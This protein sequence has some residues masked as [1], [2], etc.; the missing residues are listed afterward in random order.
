MTMEPSTVQALLLAAALGL[1]VGLQREWATREVAGIRSFALITILGA[2]TG[3]LLPQVGGW[4]VAAGLLSVAAILVVGDLVQARAG[5]TPDPGVTTE[6]AA[7]VMF[8]VGALVGSG[9]FVEGTVVGGVAALLLQWKRPLHA[10]VHALG[11]GDLRAIF[12][13]V[14]LAMVILPV[15]PNR[16]FG[17]YGVLNPF[18]IWL[19]VVLIVGISIGAYVAQR[20][21]GQ[22]GGALV[23]GFLG[24]L[25][26]ST[27][28]TVSY[29]R[30]A[31]SRPELVPAA[32]VVLLLASAVV[33][34]R[35][36]GE[37]A[38]VAP[39]EFPVMA[40][41]LVAMLAWLVVIT[42]YFGWRGK[43]E[44]EQTRPQEPEPPSELRTA[45]VFGLLYAVV[46]VGVAAA[47]EHLGGGALYLVAALSGLTDM[48]A[49]TLSTAQLA[50]AGRLEAETAWRLI[51]VGG[52]ANLVFKGGVVWL[53]APRTLFLRIAGAFAAAGAGGGG[54][55]L[56]W[57]E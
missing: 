42:L 29:A 13:F 56:L 50:R 15:L 3:I 54:I 33:F 40:P 43:R 34:V 53:M 11:E 27:A 45:I 55:L 48:D 26:S 44:L 51:L 19:M 39:H 22:R 8:L 37:I 47:R 41:P 20:I 57:P 17:P 12:Q 38:L 36:L 24:G 2:L 28:T 1:L 4:V 52:I 46:L 31:G 49:I 6:V 23:A 14:L 35:V 21:L 16:Y 7:L 30:Q 9:A 18:H 10:L 5:N 32:T 25:I